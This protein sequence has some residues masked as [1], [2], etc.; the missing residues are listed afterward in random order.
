MIWYEVNLKKVITISFWFPSLIMAMSL[1]LKWVIF[2]ACK[3]LQV[4]AV[5]RLYLFLGKGAALCRLGSM[6]TERMCE[7][8]NRWVNFRSTFLATLKKHTNDWKSHRMFIG[9]KNFSS[10]SILISVVHAWSI[11]IILGSELTFHRPYF[12]Y[13]HRFSVQVLIS[14]LSG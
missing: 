9:K 12:P 7:V 6:K 2:T 10:S 8:L 13:A 3:H 1:L 5:K 4:L 14:E 11:G